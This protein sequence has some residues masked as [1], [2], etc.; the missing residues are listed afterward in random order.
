MV[1]Y[2][3]GASEII[4]QLVGGLRSGM[5]YCGARNIKELQKNAEIIKITHASLKESH[6]HDV[7]VE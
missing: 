7:E 6:V 4:M 5:S 1:P 3:G 2:K